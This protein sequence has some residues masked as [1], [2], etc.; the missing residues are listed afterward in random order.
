[1][2]LPAEVSAASAASVLINT[3]L[4]PKTAKIGILSGNE[5][6]IKAAGDSA[7]AV[8]KKAGYNIANKT[9]INVTGQATADQLKDATAAVATMQAAGVTD[10]I[11]T[12]PF[13]VNTGFF[14]QAAALRRD[15]PLQPRRLRRVALHAVR[16]R[17]RCPRRPQPRACRA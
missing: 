13:T 3:K 2:G 8:F 14:N 11:V 4:I 10:V 5:P 9:E 17:R 7:E 1:M 6:A 15:V 12:V 16:C